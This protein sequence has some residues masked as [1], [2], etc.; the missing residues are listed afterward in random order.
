VGLTYETIRNEFREGKIDTLKSLVRIRDAD[1]LDALAD[2]LA[3]LISGPRLD[4]MS[5]ES[6]REE[7]ADGSAYVFQSPLKAWVVKGKERSA[8]ACRRCA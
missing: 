2:P 6:I 3:A 7:R 8:A 5:L 4:D 1:V